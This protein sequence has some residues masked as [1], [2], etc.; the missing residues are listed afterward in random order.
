MFR[1]ARTDRIAIARLQFNNNRIKPAR[2]LELLQVL[3]KTNSSAKT[4]FSD[5]SV[6]CRY[7]VS[8]FTKEVT[9]AFALVKILIPWP[10]T[11]YKRKT[12][13]TCNHF[14]V[15]HCYRSVEPTNKTISKF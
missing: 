5:F 15:S 2:V 12:K 1:L 13:I 9:P 8:G 14:I 6:Q 3:G 10:G 11:A 7:D 4:D